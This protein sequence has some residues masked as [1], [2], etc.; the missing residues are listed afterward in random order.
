[1][2]CDREF[3]IPGK[4]MLAGEYAVLKGATAIA[5]PTTFGQ[6]FCF[7][8]QEEGCTLVTKHR[9]K[10]LFQGCFATTGDEIAVS[11]AKK[12]AFIASVLKGARNMYGED[13][14]SFHLLINSD[15]PLEWGLGS[16]SAFLTAMAHYLQL[17]ALE[18]NEQL[19]HS[20]GY[21]VATQWHR[22]SMLFKRRENEHKVMPVK[23]DYAFSDSLYFIWTGRKSD[24]KASVQA[25]QHHLN[26]DDLAR[27][28]EPFVT[29]MAFATSLEDFIQALQAHESF[30][31]EVLEQP[32][33][34]E[35]FPE[36]AKIPA[37]WLGAW[38]G[39][40]SLLV[41][42]EEPQ[43]LRE[44]LQKA[45]ITTLIPWREMVRKN[46]R[47]QHVPS[48]EYTYKR[49][50]IT[51]AA[52]PE[53]P[54]AAQW[55]APANIA[56]IKYWGKM[57]EQQPLTPSLSFCLKH[58]FTETKVVLQRSERF[59]YSLAD[60][61]QQAW[62]KKLDTF[63]E[64]ILPYFSFLEKSHLLIDTHNTFPHGV[65]MASSASGFAALA[66]CL[67]DL[68][69]QLIKKA[70]RG[71]D[72]YR[73]ASFMARLGSGSASRSVWPGYSWWGRSMLFPQGNQ[74]MAV[75][76]TSVKGSFRNLK[77][78]IVLVDAN[79]KP[80]SS[81]EGHSRFERHPYREGR[82]AQVA[83]TIQRLKTS[84]EQ[85]DWPLFE[86]TVEQEALSLHALM[87]SAEPGYLLMQPSTVKVWQLVNDFR[88]QTGVQ[89]AMTMD[90]GPTVHLI[91]PH[92]EHEKLQPLFRELNRLGMRL[93][94]DEVGE[95]PQDLT[96]TKGPA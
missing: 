45:G 20:S 84:L 1:M 57:D 69:Q 14:P 60:A 62:R 41:W 70:H 30:L 46:S 24:T 49:E 95:G 88:Q 2:S 29:Q 33:I 40:F 71:E 51:A 94:H 8:P 37:K 3:W 85:E 86:Q 10:I 75:A 48:P 18:L 77:D 19:G 73:K 55:R 38:G 92:R 61:G 76:F 43:K 44:L 15:F 7:G 67:C 13:L 93:L 87:M 82:I 89:V 42:Q 66:L 80:V 4:L 28:I 27:R 65:G 58:S 16:S 35:I 6:S 34:Q 74:V 36:L 23:L 47:E 54:V 5:L 90:A 53:M 63:F 81:S 31:A 78:S 96:V 59:H 79:E 64:R 21:D 56:L 50:R 12:G 26:R 22:R 91:H 32:G 11:D 83:Q 52:L 17:D 9:G 25:H 39:D 72:F 68:E